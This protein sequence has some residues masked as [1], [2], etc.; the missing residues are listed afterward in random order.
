[1]D[2]LVAFLRARLDEDEAAA[3][4]NQGWLKFSNPKPDD[5]TRLM[6]DPGMGP[7]GGQSPTRNIAAGLYV[8][9][10]SDPARVLR[11]V[12]A[13]RRILLEFSIPPGT[14]AVYGGTERETGFRLALSMTLKLKGA[15]YSEHPDYKPDEWAASELASTDGN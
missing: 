11:E 15:T 7:F 13:W 3:R 2:D 8:G 12:K 6:C 14:D 10:M 9:K 1:M 5:W 4:Q